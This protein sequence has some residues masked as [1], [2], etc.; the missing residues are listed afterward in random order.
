MGRRPYLPQKVEKGVGS[1]IESI[2]LKSDIALHNIVITIKLNRAVGIPQDIDPA[3]I[4]QYSNFSVVRLCN[5]TFVVFTKAG[6]INVT[7]INKFSKIPSVLALFHS[8]FGFKVLSEQ[9]RTVCT[10]SSGQ[11]ETRDGSGRCSPLLPIGS[12]KEL[13]DQENRERSWRRRSKEKNP[14]LLS[15]HPDKFPALVAR[16]GTLIL[17]KTGRFVVVGPRS[18]RC[19]GEAAANILAKINRLLTTGRLEMQFAQDAV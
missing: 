1:Q 13:F 18:E 15:Y 8:V 12:L 16:P 10:T 6:T 17:F 11:L 3:C 7:G 5:L 9:Y 19:I 2:R 14:F 4:T